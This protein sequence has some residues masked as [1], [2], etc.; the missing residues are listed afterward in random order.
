[1]ELNEYMNLADI[2]RNRKVTFSFSERPVKEETIVDV[3]DSARFAP[4]PTGIY[5]YEFIIVEEKDQK[6]AISKACLTPNIDSAPFIVVVVCDPSKLEA[7]FDKEEA[8][9]IC[10][11]N[12]A[13]VASFIISYSSELGLSSASIT[14]LNQEKMRGLLNLRENHVVRWV[15]PLGYPSGSD[16]G[17][18]QNPPKI[19][20]IVHID[21]F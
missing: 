11:D 12:A 10:I 19:G 21:R 3:L 17:Y 4:N 2:S 15:I 1:M 8:G 18:E 6:T 13:M 20:N 5:E 9:E 16:K 7:L 14:N